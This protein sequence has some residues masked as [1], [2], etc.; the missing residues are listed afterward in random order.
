[1]IKWRLADE[2]ITADTPDELKDPIVRANLRCTIF[3]GYTSNQISCGQREIIK[4]LCQHKMVDCIV[5][6]CGG[7]EEDFMKCW[8]PHFLGDYFMKGVDLREKGLN[9]QGDLL[10][11]NRTYE[12]LEDWI[13]PL[14]EELHKEQKE[15]GEIFTP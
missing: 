15:T 7:I 3:L 10:I 6:T 5:T 12:K 9:R 11:P 1:M 14:F 4:Y 13:L 2:P 8:T